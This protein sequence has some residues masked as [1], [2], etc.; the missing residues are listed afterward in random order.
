VRE[1]KAH[2]RSKSP[3]KKIAKAIEMAD[4]SIFSEMMTRSPDSAG[5]KTGSS[6]LLVYTT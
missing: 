1:L 4:Y 5:P 3:V 2:S 6:L